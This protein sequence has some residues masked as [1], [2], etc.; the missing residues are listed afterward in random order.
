[1]IAIF[2]IICNYTIERKIN[3]APIPIAPAAVIIPITTTELPVLGTGTLV[4]AGVGLTVGVARGGVAVGKTVGVGM[5]V[6]D[7]VG[8]GLG[9]TG[10]TDG[11][12]NLLPDAYTTKELLSV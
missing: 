4:G 12:V 5:V 7:A 10:E 2:I 9:A 8:A 11:S 1:M 6:G 3:K